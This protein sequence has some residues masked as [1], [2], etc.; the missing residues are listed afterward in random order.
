MRFRAGNPSDAIVTDG[1]NGPGYADVPGSPSSTDA[2][3]GGKLV[4]ESMDGPMRRRVLALLNAF[5]RVPTEQVEALMEKH[6]DA[7]RR[8]AACLNAC[9]TWG[10]TT[11]SLEAA[12]NK[13]KWLLCVKPNRDLSDK[14]RREFLKSINGEHLAKTEELKGERT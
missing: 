13:D 10:I 12:A 3:Y 6:G 8:F 7:S 2:H 1:T 4:A 11:E 14:Q 5:S 9:A